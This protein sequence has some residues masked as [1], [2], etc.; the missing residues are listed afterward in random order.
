MI[1]FS[2]TFVVDQAVRAIRCTIS[3]LHQL[4]KQQTSDINSLQHKQA[5]NLLYRAKILGFQHHSS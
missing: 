3:R 2:L 5:T 1:M 4:L